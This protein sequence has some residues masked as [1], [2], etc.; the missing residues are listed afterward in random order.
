VPAG[1]QS[2][3]LAALARCG[4]EAAPALLA[5]GR[6][7]LTYAALERHVAGVGAVLRAQG[8]SPRDRVAV[9]LPNGPEMAA[10]FLAVASV[11]ACAPLNPAYR[12]SELDFY[13]ADLDPRLLITAGATGDEARSV[14]RARGTAI[15]ELVPLEGSAAGA[16]TLDGASERPLLAPDDVRREDEVALVLHTSGTTSR[17]K[18]VPLTH[19]NLVASARNVARSL[20]LRPDDRCLNVMPLFHIH[21]LVAAL[22]GSLYVGGSVVCSSGFDAR[23]FFDWVDELEPTWYTAVPTMH[24]AVLAQTRER[25]DVRGRFRFVR[26][27]SAA[28]PP[29]L[30]EGLEAALGAPVVEAYGMTEAAHQMASNPLPPGTRTPGSVGLPA[31]P[32]VSIL[33]EA[34]RALAAGQ[35]GEVAIRGESVFAGY[36]NNPEAN[37]GAFV[38]GWFRT[39]DEG[40]LDEDGYLVLRGRIK[41]IINRGGEKISPREVD[42]VLLEHPAIDQAVTFGVQHA[43]LGEDVAAA[44]VLRPGATVGEAELRGFVLERLSAFKVPRQFAF[45]DELPKGAT[46]KVQRIGLA[47]QLGIAAGGGAPRPVYVPPRTT[48]ERSIAALW[49]DLLSTEQ[50]GRDDD[51]FA[52]GGDSITAA[53]LMSEIVERGLVPRE[54]MAS[55][56]LLAP[57]VGRFAELLERGGLRVGNAPVVPLRTGGESAPLFL[58]HT[59]EG[60]VLHYLPIAQAVDGDRPVYALQARGVDG[61]EPPVT[62]IEEMAASYAKEIRALQPEG[63]YC[64]GGSCMGGTIAFELARNL[65]AGGAE[66]GLAVLIDPSPGR[67]SL[68]LRVCHRFAFYARQFRIHVARGDL[69][70]SLARKL[71]LSQRVDEPGASSRARAE[72]P[73]PSGKEQFLWAMVQARDTYQPRPYE[74][75]VT[76]FRSQSYDL[77]RR[78]WRSL[79]P[80][81]R[82]VELPRTTSMEQRAHFLGRELTSVLADVD[83][84]V[85]R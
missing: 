10:A 82:F 4:S 21:G 36:A 85:A 32:E 20:D 76:V 41:E 13:F 8:V 7:A 54:P 80:R 61:T 17:P 30:L 33:D 48:L 9:V 39:G 74:G 75:A 53:E 6:P 77:P 14:A 1:E 28:L 51:F 79:A 45:L 19:G 47:A 46:G 26:S 12:R 37:A 73:G 57:T 50:L 72:H 11:A 5:P 66:V 38:G 58:V 64:V 70:H 42:E 49:G 68:P 83:S 16:F 69:H 29:P 15:V 55:V 71:K 24:Q 63:P 65:A 18:M 62:S 31:G 40:Y 34:G 60:H 2:R 43:S 67:R 35:L 25:D 78:Y 56:L 52:L 44:V 81:S 3:S 59:H 23:R 84:G 22:L 27:S